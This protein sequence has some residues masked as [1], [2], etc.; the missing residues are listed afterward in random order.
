[1]VDTTFVF[2]GAPLT[3]PGQE[4]VPVTNSPVVASILPDSRSVQLGSTA[5]VFA[6]MIND[7]S[8]TLSGCQMSL[9]TDAP[10]GLT[11]NFQTTDPSSNAPTGAINTA[12]SLAPGG[13]QTFLLAFTSSSAVSVQGLA[14]VFDCA[15]TWPVNSIADVNTAD[16]SFSTTP[17]A[18]VIA[19]AATASNNG[20]VAVP[21]SSGASG[22]FAVATDN[23]GAASAITA[24]T[25]TG[26]AN[27]PI[28]VTLCQTDPTT[29][30]CLAPPAASVTVSDQ[31]GA[32]LTFSVFVAASSAVPLDPANARIFVQFTD[33]SKALRGST[34]VAVETN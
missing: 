34:S 25:T 5:T 3:D 18:D 10:A 1:V 14:P 27:L 20:I 29:A 7:S 32:T 28:T 9:P 30:A 8:V 12:T 22:A 21:F 33:A 16:L 31:A 6:N 4:I 26:E 15:S 19:L 13:T 23:L 2:I 17:T 24:A 11:L